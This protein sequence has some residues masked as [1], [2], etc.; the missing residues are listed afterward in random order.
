[1]NPIPTINIVF[2]LIIQEEHQRSAGQ[3]DSLIDPIVLLVADNSNKFALSNDR[4]TDRFRKGSN[5]QR[6]ICLHCGV[7]G[8]VV[9]R[10]YKLHGF[11][12]GYKSRSSTSSYNV[13]S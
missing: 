10:C 7:K 11:P 4:S 12:P 2:S 5:N 9:D 13:A 6:P 8:H 3:S 1:M